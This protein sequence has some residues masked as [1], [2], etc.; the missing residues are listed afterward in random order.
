MAGAARANKYSLS[1]RVEQQHRTHRDLNL[2][3]LA[4]R[5]GG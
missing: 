1:M 4:W 3:V 2:Q 5:Y